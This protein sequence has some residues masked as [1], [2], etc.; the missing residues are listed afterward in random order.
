MEQSLDSSYEFSVELNEI[1]EGVKI[2]NIDS[3]FLPSLFHS[4]VIEHHRSI[5]VLMGK[6]LYGS[7]STL[8]R[9]L[10]EAYVKGLWFSD[11]ATDIDFKKLREDK[12]K[13]EFRQ[14][15]DEI[16]SK[17]NNGLVRPKKDYWDTL[18]S[19]THTGTAQLSRKFEGNKITNS[20]N[21]KF[22][23]EILEFSGNYAMLSCCE[24]AKLASDKSALQACVLMANKK[25]GL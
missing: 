1:L 17:R 14:L 8:L 25:H 11:C 18:N 5:I 9:P 20:H 22:L 15:V 24:I 23:E 4:T 7:A 21:I 12:F 19:L 2:P 16:D 3:H 13:K 10:F 6:H